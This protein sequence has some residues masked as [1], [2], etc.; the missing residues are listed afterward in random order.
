MSTLDVV[1]HLCELDEQLQLEGDQSYKYLIETS[2]G[3][4]H[5][6][7]LQQQGNQ[8]VYERVDAIIQSYIP[9]E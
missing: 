7:E 8:Q 1:E 9:C 4:D 2:D 3:Y 6:Q 5:L